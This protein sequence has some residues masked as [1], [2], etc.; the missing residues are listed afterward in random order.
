MLILAVG[1]QATTA[2]AAEAAWVRHVIDASSKGAD[3]VRF[4]DLNGDGLPDIATGWEEGGLIR[5]YLNPG[6]KKAAAPW[7]A[8]TVGNVGD[9]ED[10]VIADVDGDG[11]PDVISSCEGKTQGLF[12]H[13]A[14]KATARLLEATAWQ[15]EAL[16]TFRKQRWMFALPLQIDGRLGLD[17]LAGGKAMGK[18][19]PLA[20]LGWFEAP[21]NPR[22]LN[23]WQWHKL[24][25]IGWLMSL[26]AEDMDGDGD[27]DVIFTD[28]RD[29]P[30]T[31]CF[32]LENPGSIE[33]QRQTWKEH[34]IGGAGQEVMFA[35]VADLDQDGKRDVLA[36]V[37]PQ[38]ILWFRRLDARG[39]SWKSFS[40]RI[41]ENTG[42]AKAVSVGDIDLDGKP[43]LVYSCEQAANGKHGLG[44][45]SAKAG[46]LSGQ[47]QT[48]ELSGADGVKH[49]LAPLIDL[50]GDGDLDVVTTEEVKNL[51]VI[52]Y[53]NPTRMP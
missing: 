24:R 7:P 5:L 22:Q 45:L 30:R 9:P 1:W 11:A 37:L 3:G 32:W 47:W 38:T 20:E 46:P 12:V 17:L 27:L 13:W 51:G 48:H 44:W 50:D 2:L 14:P 19:G 53:E 39:E 31:G 41:P 8:V 34:L 16:P 28:R 21:P 10:A 6:P 43:D 26:I 18:N 29:G 42:R 35:T 36:A 52:W 33:A 25:E 40:I 15:T 4:A 49:D 23:N